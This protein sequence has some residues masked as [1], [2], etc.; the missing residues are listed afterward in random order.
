[1]TAIII[2]IAN[3]ANHR[4]PFTAAFMTLLSGPDA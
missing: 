3:I 2:G 1:M 4:R